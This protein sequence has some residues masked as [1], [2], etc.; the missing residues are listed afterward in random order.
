M[1]LDR[2]MKSMAGLLTSH[3]IVL[4]SDVIMVKRN[5]IIKLS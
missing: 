1:P 4:A 5:T 3:A 2:A